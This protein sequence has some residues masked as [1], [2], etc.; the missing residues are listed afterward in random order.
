VKIRLLWILVACLA[1]IFLV[2]ADRSSAK[3]PSRGGGFAGP[4]PYPQAAIVGTVSVP[5][6]TN[7]VTHGGDNL[8]THSG[9]EIVTH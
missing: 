2:F 9:L 8:V 5:S 1:L 4:Y 6:G 3:R 7:I